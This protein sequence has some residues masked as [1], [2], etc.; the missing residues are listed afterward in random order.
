M[1]SARRCA[2]SPVSVVGAISAWGSGGHVASASGLSGSMMVVRSW[3]YGIMTV[4]AITVSPIRCRRR[5]SHAQARPIA[6]RMPPPINVGDKPSASALASSG[7][8]SDS[9]G[10]G[11]RGESALPA[12]GCA[13][14]RGSG[15]AS[16][17]ESGSATS[18]LRTS[19]QSSLALWMRSSRSLTVALS[20]VADKAAC[21]ST[22]RTARSAAVTGVAGKVNSCASRSAGAI[23]ASGGAAIATAGAS[24][25]AFST[26]RTQFPSKVPASV[27]AEPS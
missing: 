9:L 3:P 18:S 23:S 4:D 22:R 1:V 11:G 14:G 15:C 27:V 8:G 7:A 6:A 21:H 16:G 26:Y 20:V 12:S 10:G 5:R 24:R 17:R 25:M 2:V 13:S 19:A